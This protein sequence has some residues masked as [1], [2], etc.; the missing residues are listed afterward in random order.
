MRLRRLE[1]RRRLVS[2]GLLLVFGSTLAI[3]AEPVSSPSETDADERAQVQVLA[4]GCVNCHESVAGAEPSIP[5]LTGRSSD[6]L[7]KLLLEFKVAAPV[8]TTVMDRI[9]KGFRD[10]ELQ[11]LAVYFSKVK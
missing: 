2:L 4:A 7:S 10:E 3:A 11:R 1:L 6:E 5:R 9:A 8:G